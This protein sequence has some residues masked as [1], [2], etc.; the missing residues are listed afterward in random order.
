MISAVVTIRRKRAYSKEVG[1]SEAEAYKG[2]SSGKD[3]SG[4]HCR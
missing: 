3:D 4:R 1:T 2:E